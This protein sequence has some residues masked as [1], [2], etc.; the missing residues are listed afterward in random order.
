VRFSGRAPQYAVA[1]WPEKLDE[2]SDKLSK[3]TID[4]V[5]ELSLE[6]KG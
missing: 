3:A 1:W 4:L 2:V 5:A 6:K